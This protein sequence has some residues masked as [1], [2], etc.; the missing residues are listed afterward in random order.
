MDG[1]DDIGENSF[2]EIIEKFGLNK[3]DTF[4]TNPT[5]KLLDPQNL[6]TV[7]TH[8]RNVIST[9]GIFANVT[10]PQEYKRIQENALNILLNTDAPNPAEYQAVHDTIWNWDGQDVATMTQQIVELKA[11]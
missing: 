1:Y 5:V 3:A 8:E 10:D 7:I 11:E 6:T 4:T 9:G 2:E